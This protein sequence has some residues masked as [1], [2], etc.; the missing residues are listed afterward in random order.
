M[1]D[2]QHDRPETGAGDGRRA[3]TFREKGLSQPPLRLHRQR[4]DGGFW[5]RARR[6]QPDAGGVSKWESVDLFD[7]SL[8]RLEQ[9]LPTREEDDCMDSLEA[10]DRALRSLVETEETAPRA[11]RPPRQEPAREVSPEQAMPALDRALLQAYRETVFT[12][13]APTPLAL[14]IGEADDALRV[15]HAKYAV[16]ES[17][18]VTAHNPF[19]ARLADGENARRH[20]AL[21]AELRARGRTFFEGQGAHP[22]GTWPAEQ[23]VLALGVG[24]A[25]AA[26]LGRRWGQN[27]VVWCGGDAV[28]EL[29][30]LRPVTAEE[31][32]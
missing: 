14:R 20:G 26:S 9:T 27:A 28:P 13:Q 32:R 16:S 11:A 6:R 2:P 29:L 12:L 7:P 1:S 4:R 8:P 19:S 25:E 15:V 3:M 5:I 24:R 18:F 22:T 10:T 23:G 17:C 21:C 31:K 30:V